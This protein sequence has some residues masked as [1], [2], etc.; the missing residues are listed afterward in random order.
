M[1]IWYAQVSTLQDRHVLLTYMD[2]SNDSFNC[3]PL[4]HNV[5][6]QLCGDA[7]NL[8]RRHECHPTY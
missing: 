6:L 2:D 5:V 7:Q 4:M 3:P 8:E 1:T